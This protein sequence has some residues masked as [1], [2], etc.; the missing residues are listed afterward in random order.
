MG[1][2][3]FTV[4]QL[5]RGRILS[6]NL[7]TSRI[8]M[9]LKASVV[10][11]SSTRQNLS[12][13]DLKVG[14]KLRGTV[15]AIQPYGIFISIGGEGSKLSGLCHVTQVSDTP[16][17]DVSSLYSVGDTVKA[18]ILNI[19]EPI[20]DSVLAFVLR[21]AEIDKAR[22]ITERALKVI[23]FREGEKMN[24]WVAYLNL[25]YKFGTQESLKKVFERGVAY[26][27]PKSMHLQM[28]RIYERTDKVELADEL[29]TTILKKFKGSSKCWTSAALFYLRN[30]RIED[31]RRLLQRCLLSLPKHK[32]VKTLSKFAQIEFRYGEAERGRTVFEGILSNYPKRVDVWNVFIDIERRMGD[33]IVRQSIKLKVSSKKIKFV[34][35]R[36]LE[37]EKSIGSGQGVEHVK[38]A[39]K[40][41]RHGGLGDLGAA[42][43][44]KTWSCGHGQY[45]HILLSVV[46]TSTPTR[47]SVI[48]CT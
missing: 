18:V 12:L 41:P 35:K 38:E 13:S 2:S 16:V 11:G 9:S 1:K 3:L 14:Q 32:H 31:A 8:E 25:E 22:A 30:C 33:T 23:N 46:M 43:D 27:D 29:Y 37:F 19:D 15:K 24:V 36:Y 5:V 42:P 28:A 10:D 45:K 48:S 17:K 40:A 7:V 26:N 47:V 6:V 4:G 44:D 39:A 21:L 20:V 34:F